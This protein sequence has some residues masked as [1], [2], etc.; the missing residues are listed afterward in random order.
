MTAPGARTVLCKFCLLP[1]G[2]AG[3]HEVQRTVDQHTGA[4]MPAALRDL[5][6][7]VAALADVRAQ[8]STAVGVYECP[9]GSVFEFWEAA[10]IEDYVALNRRLGMHFESVCMAVEDR[11]SLQARVQELTALCAAQSDDLGSLRAQLAEKTA[12]RV[13]GW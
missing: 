5:D 12:K 8:I 9:R 7:T 11:D 1:D 4:A 2:H 3:P 6:D 13:R 10:S